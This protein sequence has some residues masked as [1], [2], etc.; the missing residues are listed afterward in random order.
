MKDFKGVEYGSIASN[1][2]N[3]SPNRVSLMTDNYSPSF[4]APTR[5]S[6]ITV[7]VFNVLNTCVGGGTLSVPYAFAKCGWLVASIFVFLSMISTAF[8]MKLLCTMSRKLG[9]VSYSDVME[10]TLGSVGKRLSTALLFGMLFLVVIAFLV[11]LKDISGDIVQFFTPEGYILGDRT[12][13]VITIFLTAICFPLMTADQLHSLRFVSYAGTICVSILLISISQEAYSVRQDNT[14]DSV[15][16]GPVHGSDVFTALPIIFISF[17]CQFNI[18]GVYSDLHQP[19]EVNMNAVIDRSMV[20]AATLFTAF[21]LAGYLFAH[22]HTADNILKN[23]SPRD[24]S[25]LIARIGLTLT[26]L[27]QL[28]MV[29]L[30]CRQ[31]FYPLMWPEINTAQNRSQHSDRQVVELPHPSSFYG[32]G[33]SARQG[34]NRVRSLSGQDTIETSVYVPVD[35]GFDI[36]V[37]NHTSRYTI[38]FILVIVCLFLS[39][40]IPGVSTVWSIAGST[41]SIVIAFLLPSYAYLSLWKQLGPSRELDSYVIGAYGLL[42]LSIL[43]IVL[44][45]FQTMLKLFNPA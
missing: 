11:L 42:L 25:L 19:T 41:L 39:Q 31:A 32:E 33:A 26:L 5:V 20:V 14:G 40:A 2:R 28:P 17:L 12:K 6:S 34:P 7:G 37:S 29:V 13:N 4:E 23:F 30:P 38:T 15:R 8:S 24:P 18:L 10:K 27:C 45:T 16:W 22:D 1:A 43:L 35:E 9:C 3:S 44:C 21:G 36:V